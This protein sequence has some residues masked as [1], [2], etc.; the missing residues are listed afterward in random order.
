MKSVTIQMSFSCKYKIIQ[1]F[2]T[3]IKKIELFD[4]VNKDL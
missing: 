4:I 3:N 2:I 1:I